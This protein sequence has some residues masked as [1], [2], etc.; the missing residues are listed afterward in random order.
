M[1]LHCYQGF[2]LPPEQQRSRSESALTRTGQW[3]AC[4]LPSCSTCHSDCTVVQTVRGAPVVVAAEEE[5]EVAVVG[6]AGGAAGGRWETSTECNFRVACQGCP[7]V[8]LDSSGRTNTGR[9]RGRGIFSQLRTCRMTDSLWPS[10]E[11]SP[12][13]GVQVAVEARAR[14]GRRSFHRTRL[15]R[16]HPNDRCRGRVPGS[17]H[18]PTWS[19]SHRSSRSVHRRCRVWKTVR[20]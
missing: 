4:H 9:S 7:L 8:V 11:A 13:D 16:V 17:H 12:V 6:V 14:R 18:L 3:F 20:W 2:P 1:A 5:E 15:H 10:R 19:C